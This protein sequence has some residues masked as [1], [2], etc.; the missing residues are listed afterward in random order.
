MLQLSFSSVLTRRHLKLTTARKYEIAAARRGL[1]RGDGRAMRGSSSSAPPRSTLRAFLLTCCACR[2]AAVL[3]SVWP[4]LSCVVRTRRA[5]A[6]RPC[7]GAAPQSKPQPSS[8]SFLKALP[9]SCW[10]GFSVRDG[11]RVKGEG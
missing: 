10:G 3:S 8:V 9:K 4:L 6:P 1:S 7:E 2:P 11:L 5:A